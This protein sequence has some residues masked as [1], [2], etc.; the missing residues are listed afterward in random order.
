MSKRPIVKVAGCTMRGKPVCDHVECAARMLS[1][2][3]QEEAEEVLRRRYGLFRRRSNLIARSDHTYLELTPLRA[4]KFVPEDDA[5]AAAVRAI[6]Q[7]RREWNQPPS[8][9]AA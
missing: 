4:D 3:Q 8:P 2:E 1:P 7:V 9:G 6:H 5:E